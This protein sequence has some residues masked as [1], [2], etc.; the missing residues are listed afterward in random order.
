MLYIF[1]Y[2]LK[3]S[4]SNSDFQKLCHVKAKKRTIPSSALSKRSNPYSLEKRCVEDDKRVR[5][6]RDDPLVEVTK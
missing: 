3:N 2:L 5:G 6:T 1:I 4:K